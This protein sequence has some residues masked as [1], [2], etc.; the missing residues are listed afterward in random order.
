MDDIIRIAQDNKSN[1]RLLRK[2]SKKKVNILNI[3]EEVVEHG[4]LIGKEKL[5]TLTM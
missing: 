5:L 2:L 4:D 3:A 1:R